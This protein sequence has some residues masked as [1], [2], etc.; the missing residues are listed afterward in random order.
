MTEYYYFIH[1]NIADIDQI[2]VNVLLAG[3]E[4]DLM[5]RRVLCAGTE[6]LAR[7]IAECVE[8]IELERD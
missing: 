8:P 1:I 7:E 3:G 5:A 4:F 2:N 6:K